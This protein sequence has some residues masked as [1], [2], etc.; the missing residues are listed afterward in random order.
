MDV[1][2]ITPDLPVSSQLLVSEMQAVGE[3]GFKAK[4]WYKLKWWA[5]VR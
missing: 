1:K 4:G 5:D 2:L 3:A